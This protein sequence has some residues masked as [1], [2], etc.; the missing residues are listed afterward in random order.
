[1][2][3]ISK[4]PKTE[5]VDINGIFT[6]KKGE[7]VLIGSDPDK[8]QSPSGNERHI[9]I[10]S[11]P[12]VTLS[13]REIEISLN[14]NGDPQIKRLSSR[15]RHP[16]FV[17]G[18]DKD[19][20]RTWHKNSLVSTLPDSV[21]DRIKGGSVTVDIQLGTQDEKMVLRLNGVGGSLNTRMFK[22]EL[23]PRKLDLS[24]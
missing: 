1:M 9:Q 21:Y 15:E 23:N 7:R 12:G 16:I 4:F 24:K 13:P 3:E 5:I 19:R 17:W 18:Q 20:G 22:V 14:N 10:K 11:L 8:Q 2:E 6:V